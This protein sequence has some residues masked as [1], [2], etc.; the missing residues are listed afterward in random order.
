MMSR[1]A[2]RL[3][4]YSD[5]GTYEIAITRYGD[6]RSR[7][8][9]LCL[10][11]ILETS[12]GFHHLIRQ[13]SSAQTF[14]FDFAGRGASDYLPGVSSYR[15]SRCLREAWAAYAYLL[16]TFERLSG[17]GT[18]QALLPFDRLL[19]DKAHVHLVGN[20]MGG[21]LGIFMA[22]QR[23]AALCSLVINDVGSLISWSSLIS[24][25]GALSRTSILPQSVHGL[26]GGSRQLAERLD[27]DHKLMSA[28][29]QP[30]YLDLAHSREIAGLSFRPAFEAVE[31][32]V[33]V[34]RSEDSPI[35]TP[36]VH[37]A[38][39]DLPS[40]YSFLSVEGNA[41]PAAYSENVCE[42]IAE[43]MDAAE[44]SST[45]GAHGEMVSVC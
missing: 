39:H 20:S 16:G 33:L 5:D 35:F 7:R 14:A 21:L 10:P 30:S 23:P 41:H 6:A 26:S 31:V 11:G 2:R 29:M 24:L 28:I 1:T 15:M 8:R 43:F 18:L 3:P 37:K 12:E 4:V 36:S 32:P 25:Y 34:I 40:N 19:S 45:P 17:A 42:K 9:L 44:A 38:M 27:V 13:M 22:G